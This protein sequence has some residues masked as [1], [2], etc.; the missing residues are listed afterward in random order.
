MTWRKIKALGKHERAIEMALA[1][2]YVNQESIIQFF[3]D[4][5]LYN[6]REAFMMAPDCEITFA[7]ALAKFN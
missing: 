4:L 1:A 5:R 6:L 7:L 3:R 2:D